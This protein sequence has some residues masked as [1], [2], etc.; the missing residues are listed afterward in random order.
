LVTEFA[1]S[2]PVIGLLKRA[3]L[4]VTPLGGD[5]TEHVVDADGG[6]SPIDRYY[7]AGRA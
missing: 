7:L 1:E 2:G 5:C 4:A 6:K 3:L